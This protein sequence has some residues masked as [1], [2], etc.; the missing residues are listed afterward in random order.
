[1]I[2]KYLPLFLVALV[3]L[4]LAF[5]Y[6]CGSNA[7]SGGGSSGGVTI[8]SNRPGT[9][10]YSGTQSPGDVWTWTIS[11]ETF[12]GS[13]ETTGF[14]VSGTWETLSNGFR[15]AFVSAANP[16]EVQGQ[17]A[18]FLEFPNTMLMIHPVCSEEGHGDNIIVCTAHSATPPSA[19]KYVY[20][21]IPWQGWTTGNTAY[22]SVEVTNPSGWHFNV[23]DFLLGGEPVSNFAPSPD[24]SFNNGIMKNTTPSDPKI[25]M[26]PTGVF[27]GDNGASGGFA[28]ASVEAIDITDLSSKNYRGVRFVYD[29]VNGSNETRPIT[30]YPDGA[31]KMIGREYPNGVEAGADSTNYVVITFEAQDPGSGII[32]IYITDHGSGTITYGTSTYK[33]VA[34]QVGPD[35]ADGKYKYMIFAFGVE[36]GQP[37]NFLVMQVD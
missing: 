36:G 27:M 1:M 12:L 22:G 3:V 7:T 18:Y 28:G 2:K 26:T 17:V 37:C 13:D 11:P 34:A 8:L 19:G 16:T 5:I 15:K 9:Y 4:S 32:P 21:T 35:A 10:E 31:K 25:F 24:Y 20:V 33:G 6:G 14:W 29:A 23:T 30:A